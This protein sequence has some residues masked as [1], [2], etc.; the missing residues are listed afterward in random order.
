MGGGSRLRTPR[1]LRV[2]C[3]GSGQENVL[4]SEAGPGDAEGVILLDLCSFVSSSVSSEQ[5]LAGGLLCI[6]N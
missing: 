2:C 6:L 3:G 5:S 1:E 4:G